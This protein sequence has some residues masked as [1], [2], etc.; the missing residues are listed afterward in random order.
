LLG[1][2]SIAVSGNVRSLGVTI[3]D[4]L[5]FNT[6]VNEVCK[7]ANYHLRAMR[8]IRKCISVD[9]AK[10]IAVSMVSAKLDYCN[11][12]LYK[13]TQSNLA[14]V[15]RLQN[16]LARVV[17]NTRKYEHITPVLAE[18]HWLPVTARIE[19]KIALLTYKT[20]VTKQ[21]SYLNELIHVHLPIRS[22]R[23]A[24]QNNRLVANSS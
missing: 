16:S 5:S 23:S 10:L 2:T 4:T 1:S 7:A 15:Q 8:H 19:Y 12:M 18:L 9:D 22:L 24:K 13:T 14:N 6:H 20:L 3:D 21:P 17:T 11:S